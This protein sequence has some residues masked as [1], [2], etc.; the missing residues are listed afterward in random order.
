[1]C[2]KQVC[3]KSGEIFSNFFW[4]IFPRPLAVFA[5]M[6]GSTANPGMT[7]SENSPPPNALLSGHGSPAPAGLRVDPFEMSPLSRPPSRTMRRVPPLEAHMADRGL[8]S[9]QAADREVELWNRTHD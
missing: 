3:S 8:T 9:G 4:I 5:K 6:V 7:M 2:K 1:M